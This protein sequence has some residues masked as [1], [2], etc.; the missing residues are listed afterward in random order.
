MNATQLA[1]L[2]A[3]GW[4][5]DQIRDVFNVDPG[6]KLARQAERRAKQQRQA[7]I[8]EDAAW[9]LD[10]GCLPDEIAR[11]VDATVHAVQYA[12]DQHDPDTGLRFRAARRKDGE[13]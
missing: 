10:N 1:A 6:P 13:T 9:L 3:T 11:R 12:L 4:T 5:H 8:A 7:A 2:V